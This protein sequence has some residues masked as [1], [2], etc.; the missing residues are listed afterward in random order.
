MTA[1]MFDPVPVGSVA[2]PR[3]AA[4]EWRIIMPMPEGVPAPPARHPKLGAPYALGV[5]RCRGPAQ[6][7][8][9]PF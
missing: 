7:V 4:P 3:P 5:S 6:R 1:G 9:L 2:A 8:C